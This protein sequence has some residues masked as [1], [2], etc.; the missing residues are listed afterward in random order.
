MANTAGLIAL[1]LAAYAAPQDKPADPPPIR[2]TVKEVPGDGK[3]PPAFHCEGEA[4]VPDGSRIDVYYYFGEV[5]YGG[6]I[7]RGVAVVKEGKFSRDSSIFPKRTLPGTYGVRVLFNPGLQPREELQTLPRRS[8]DQVLKVGTDA[9]IEKEQNAV[10]KRMAEHIES[11]RSL[12]DEIAAKQKE[13]GGKPDKQ[14]WAKLIDGWRQRCLA[15]EARAHKDTDFVILGLMPVADMGLEQMRNIM[16][17]VAHCAASGQALEMKEGLTRLDLS[18]RKFTEMVAVRPEDPQKVRLELAGE[19]RRI[20]REAAR[21]EGP[22]LA[23]SRRKFLE[24]VLLLNR[25]VPDPQREA[26]LAIA[27][28]AKD[29]FDAAADRKEG[30]PALQEKLDARFESLLRALQEGK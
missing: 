27:A 18:A 29:L 17:A 6:E 9:E 16:L 10:R 14:T 2:F 30:V 19:A 1:A 8:A 5:Q 26:V 21:Q 11:V 7:H 15:V 3:T 22:A 28:E 24:T 13:S 4:D 25:H 12:G 20:A 23:A